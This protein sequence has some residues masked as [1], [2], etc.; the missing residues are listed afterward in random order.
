MAEIR[1]FGGVHYSKKLLEDWPAVICPVYDII[2]PQQ[3]Q[4]LYLRSEYN[5]VRLE[6]ARELPQDTATN[7]KYTRVAATL[8]QWLEQGV[9][10]ADEQ[11]AIYL[12]D[13]HFTYRDKE[14]RRRSLIVRVRLE[15]WENNVVRPHEGTMT[16]PKADRLNLLWATQ[17][18]TSPVLALYDDPGGKIAT[19]LE[20]QEKKEPHF[21][22]RKTAGEG[23][24]IWALTD[25]DTVKQVRCLLADQPLYIADGHHRYESALAYRR[26]KLASSPEAADGEAGFNFVMMTLVDF[27]DPGLLILPPHRLVRG[28]AHP[29]L[30]ELMPKLKIFFDIEKLPLGSPDIWQKVDTWLAS[31]GGVNLALYGP[32][33][34]ALFLLT[35]RDPAA[36]SEMVPYFHSEIYKR[37]D[38][39][40][41]DHVILEE[42]LELDREKE[43]QLRAYT[44]DE[45]DAINRVQA[46]EYQLAFLLRPV[47]P[48]TIKAIADA[49]DRMPNKST[50][51][52]PKTPAGLMVNLLR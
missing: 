2:T 47:R 27:A 41:L 45:K 15:E 19:I 35:L 51:F 7:S 49:G 52:Y 23:H 13:Q 21:D 39:S 36:V 34:G 22:L 20:T 29:A 4:E 16:G 12:H 33:P 24:C 14:Y 38:V 48:E 17:A 6:F 46:Q 44:Y 40:V 32:N 18:N 50:Y 42:F 5:F 43:E 11:P 26:Q 9:L 28:I 3:Q 1:P 8:G 31:V 30:D 25:H 37:L 10:V